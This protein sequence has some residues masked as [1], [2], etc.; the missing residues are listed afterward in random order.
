[1]KNALPFELQKGYI[2]ISDA[3]W[4]KEYGFPNLQCKTF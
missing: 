2:D 1:M 4:S 3:L